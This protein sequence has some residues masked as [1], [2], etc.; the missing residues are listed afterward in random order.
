MYIFSFNFFFLYA[1]AALC[2]GVNEKKKPTYVHYDLRVEKSEFM[3]NERISQTSISFKFLEN[4]I[5]I[6]ENEH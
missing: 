3:E 5:N 4:V 1:A 2:E 6:H